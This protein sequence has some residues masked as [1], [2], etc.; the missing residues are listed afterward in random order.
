MWITRD[1]TS[2]VDDMFVFSALFDNIF[3]V[4]I[5]LENHNSA[6]IPSVSYLQAES[7]SFF[8][9]PFSGTNFPFMQLAD[10]AAGTII[11]EAGSVVFDVK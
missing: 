7:A 5:L 9:T 6:F 3:L 1:K 11:G 2:V 10:T 4:A 8:D